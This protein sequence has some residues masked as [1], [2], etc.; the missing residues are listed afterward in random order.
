VGDVPVLPSGLPAWE[1]SNDGGLVYHYT[2]FRGLMGIVKQQELWATDVWYMNDTGEAT[3]S[4]G[5]VRQFLAA[6][7]PE[8]H[9]IEEICK[10][11]Q[12]LFDGLERSIVDDWRRDINQQNYIACLSEKRDDLSQWRSYG[13]LSVGFDCGALWRL[14]SK[15]DGG[16][17]MAKV[18]YDEEKQQRTLYDALQ[19]AGAALVTYRDNSEMRSR[20][21]DGFT[22]LDM[23]TGEFISHLLKICTSF[24]HP[25]FT[26]EEE[27]RISTTRSFDFGKPPADVEFCESS[28]GI[29]PHVDIP[30][31]L[32]GEE[33][34]SVIREIIIGPQSHQREAQRAVGQ[35][36]A[37]RGLADVDVV[38]SEIPLRS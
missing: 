31:C 13:S 26:A 1:E 28:L 10:G 20:L 36:L 27:I 7:K 22:P 30:L 19:Q 15:S 32:P 38:P 12:K 18:I 34:M 21:A 4:L 3:Y 37:S 5:R 16:S 24:K 8:M 9:D 6:Y 25:A 29:T 2:N 23:A 35:F 33:R 11:A 17:E 14:F